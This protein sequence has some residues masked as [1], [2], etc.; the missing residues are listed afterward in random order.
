VTVADDKRALR[1]R[2]RALRAAVPPDE[3]AA[4]SAEIERRLL[5][6]PETR[7]ASCVFVFRSFGS[8]VGTHGL[9]EHLAA[10]DRRVAIPVLADGELRA[11]AYVLGD[12]LVPSGYG[13]MEPGQR[14]LVDP[15]D[16]GLIVL[17]GLAF[18]RNGF[19]LGYGGGY[20]DRY[21]HRSGPDIPRVA[22]AFH[23]QVLD[24]VPHDDRDERVDTGV[25]DREVIRVVRP[26]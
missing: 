23:Q 2:M 10:S 4:M 1:E 24:R 3:R 11:A 18:D 22:V 15:S 25:T 14:T 19:R 12:P 26:P 5:A 6:L 9:I 16:V 17:P 21:L 8:E 13:A 7:A 20:Y